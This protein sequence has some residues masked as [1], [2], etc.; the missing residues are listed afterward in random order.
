MRLLD[1]DVRYFDDETPGIPPLI[2]EWGATVALLDACLVTGSLPQEV[3]SISSKESEDG[4][5]LT[6]LLLSE[7][8]GFKKE[9]SVV[10]LSGC[11]DPVYNTVHR[12]QEV[13]SNSITIAF[14]MTIVVDKPRDSSGG[15]LG[16]EVRHAP[17][18]YVKA[19]ED[20]NKAVYKIKDVSGRTCY[21]RVDNSCPSGYDLTWGKFAR[22]SILDSMDYI[23]DYR[24]RAG[25]LKA[26]S[27][28]EDFNRAEESKGLGKTG[29]YGSSKWYQRLD[30]ESNYFYE[31]KVPKS[32]GPGKWNLIGDS[33]TF[34]YLPAFF[35]NTS[36][37]IRQ[38]FKAGYC[39]GEYFDLNNP[40]N[41][42]NHLLICHYHDDT[43]STYIGHYDHNPGY[44]EEKNSFCRTGHLAGK[45]M[46]NPYKQET[47][48][49]SGS[50]SF[51]FQSLANNNSISGT[52]YTDNEVD[53]INSVINIFPMYIK[54]EG[55]IFKGLSRG[56][57]FIGNDEEDLNKYGLSI[58]TGTVITNFHENRHIKMVTLATS[59]SYRRSQTD[60]TKVAF[61]LNNWG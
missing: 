12:V 42:N 49:N 43:A 2:N 34:Y 11:E 19:F 20:D 52:S 16:M 30:Y 3:R 47:F 51:S 15:F 50:D 59:Y 32:T 56:Y 26:P 5:W 9:L 1:T 7:D 10:L 38:E 44:I 55:G 13:S 25:R 14:D 37:S 39:F 41:V 31:Y 8:H 27:I 57:F 23:D 28:K 48:L 35:D 61:K 45:F 40:S 53:P 4:F 6:T 60:T 24:Y 17:L 58:S 36:T 22:V 33:R 46:L 54:T 18:G 21:L 29:K